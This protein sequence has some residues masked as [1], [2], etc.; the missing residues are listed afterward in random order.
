MTL[1]IGRLAMPGVHDS[2]VWKRRRDGA[3]PS[4]SPRRSASIP[5]RLGPHTSMRGHGLL[6]LTTRG[7]AHGVPP[8]ALRI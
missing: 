6:A 1:V 2:Q 4:T 5:Q 3:V 7:V 8:G